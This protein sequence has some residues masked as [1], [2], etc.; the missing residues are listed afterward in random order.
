M[1]FIIK[2]TF[3]II[4]VSFLVSGCQTKPLTSIEKS[5]Q[6]KE[7]SDKKRK[8]EF[9]KAQ[10]KA[11]KKHYNMQPESTKEMME[12]NKRASEQWMNRNF[13][14]KPFFEQIKDFFRNLKPKPKPD[15]GLY[16]KKQKRK[17]KKNIFQRIFKKKK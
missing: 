6:A 5:Q 12:Q 11:R 8:E 2:Q 15:K 7:K 16:T 9:R 10:E 4:S 1:L 13:Q 14:R 3:F 17:S